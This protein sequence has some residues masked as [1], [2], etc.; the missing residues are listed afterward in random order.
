[1]FGEQGLA[2]T[3]RRAVEALA[4]KCG[5]GSSEVVMLQSRI[6]MESEGAFVFLS[7]LSPQEDWH[8][9]G[10][11]VRLY[12]PGK[13]LYW[14][15]VGGGKTYRV[16]CADLTMKWVALAAFDLPFGPPV[17]PLGNDLF[18]VAFSYR[19]TA[20]VGSVYLVGS[21]NDWN[22]TGHKMDG[23]DKEGR[24]HTRL[25]LKKG[26]CEYKFVVDGQTWKPDPN[27][28]WQSEPFQDSEAHVGIL[29][30]SPAKPLGDDQFE[31]TFRYRPRGAARSVYL[32]GSFN[33]WNPTGHKMDGPDREG[34]FYT[35]LKLHK[36]LYEYKFVVDGQTWETDPDNVWRT[37]PNRNS[38]IHVGV[39]L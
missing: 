28:I 20:P 10:R 18:E 29:L 12:T 34:R 17:K 24:F 21:F 23:P 33:D 4:Q 7:S 25:K 39:G 16:L 11:D 32:A 37:G 2:N 22:P 13:P 26:T 8:Y 27:N 1:L 38:L 3:L 14:H 6:A 30:G 31:V 35:R 5:A 36:G 19:P 9:A 15:N